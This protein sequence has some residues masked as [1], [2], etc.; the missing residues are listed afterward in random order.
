MK[1]SPEVKARRLAWI[2]RLERNED[3]QTQWWLRDRSG[4]CCLGVYCDMR[5]AEL[6]AQWEGRYAPSGDEFQFSVYGEQLTSGLSKDLM[7]ELHM[8]YQLHGHCQL[9]NDKGSTFPQIAAMLRH[10]WRMPKESNA[11]A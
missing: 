8:T 1:I 6:D 2:E 3:P 7:E 9:M 4:F 10:R 11:A 5:L